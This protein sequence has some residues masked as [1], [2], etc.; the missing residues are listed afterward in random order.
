MKKLFILL[1]FISIAFVTTA[2]T[3]IPV[4]VENAFK[5]KFPNAQNVKWAKESKTEYE[6]AFTINGKKASA[7]FNTKGEWVETEMQIDAS[8]IPA[9]AVNL[10]KEKYALA[11]IKEV[12]SI[13]KADGKKEY[14]VEITI[15]KKSK[16]L[17]FDKDWKFIK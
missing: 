4:T 11:T 8:A 5:Q 10:I 1:S 9:A 7:N 16:E 6:A 14:E 13:E 17:F 2:Q 12:Y 15:N 3:K